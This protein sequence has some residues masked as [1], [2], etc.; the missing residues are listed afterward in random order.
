MSRRKH[1]LW[2]LG[3]L[4]VL[5]SVM[6]LGS[7][8]FAQQQ[9]DQQYPSQTTPS[10]QQPQQTPPAQQP[11]DQ[12]APPSSAD[13]QMAGEQVFSGTI[14]KSGGKYVLQDTSGKTYD[15]DHQELLKEHEGKQVRIK[16]MLDADGKTIHIK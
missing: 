1:H 15:L 3:M 11:P 6:L 2:G 5:A 12:T 8:I 9:S 10:Q 14:T 13:S 4:A 16:G 7:Q